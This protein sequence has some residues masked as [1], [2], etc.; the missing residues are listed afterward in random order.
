MGHV[1][2]KIKCTTFH[3]SFLNN[4]ILGLKTNIL[5]PDLDNKYLEELYGC[6]RRV[7]EIYG[8]VMPFLWI[9]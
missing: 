3:I 7:R 2:L 8:L 4:S 1:Y 6:E 5:T 9:K